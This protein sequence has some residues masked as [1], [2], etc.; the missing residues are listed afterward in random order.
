MNNPDPAMRAILIYGSDAGAVREHSKSI[1]KWAL[2]D[3]HDPLL[4]VRLNEDELAQDPAKLNDEAS[5]IAMFGGNKV[6][7][8]G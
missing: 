5:A 1:S 4:M 3:N 7:K 6:L 8:F 2:G